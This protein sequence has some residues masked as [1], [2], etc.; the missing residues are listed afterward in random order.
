MVVNPYINVTLEATARI[1]AP[2]GINLTLSAAVPRYNEVL[3]AYIIRTHSF[4][5]KWVRIMRGILR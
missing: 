2:F 1:L 5:V 3:K 4:D